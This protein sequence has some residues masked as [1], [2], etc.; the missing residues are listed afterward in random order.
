MSSLTSLV[1]FEWFEI[2]SSSRS[3]QLRVGHSSTF[4]PSLSNIYIIG[5]A[6]PSECFAD[7]HSL[8]LPSKTSETFIWT[9]LIGEDSAL[10]RYEHSAVLSLD[11]NEKIVFFGGAN[12]ENNFNDVHVFDI[13]T[14]TIEDWTPKDNKLVTPRT[15]HS[16]CCI[17]NGLYIFSGGS[18]GVKAVDDAELYRFD[19]GIYLL[20]ELFKKIFIYL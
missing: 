3:P 1:P 9:K 10:R 4:I 18:Q 8:S 17:Q 13:S 7:I 5:G 12:T 11:N 6:N 14:K 15:H 19:F 2:H 16:S 20:I